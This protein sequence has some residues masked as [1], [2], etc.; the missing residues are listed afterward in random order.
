MSIPGGWS[1]YTCDITNDAMDAFNTAFEG[2]VGVSYSP[3]SC[4]SQVVSGMNYSFFCN[5]LGVYPGAFPQAS[6][7]DI[8]K[9]LEGKPEIKRIKIIEH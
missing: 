5:S 1:K 9:P 8:Y 4:A 3:V 6:I 7:V 2:F